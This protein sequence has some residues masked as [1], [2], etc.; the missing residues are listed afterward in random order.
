MVHLVTE[1]TETAKKDLETAVKLLF[2]DAQVTQENSNPTTEEAN[3]DKQEKPIS[4][5]PFALFK[6]YF[7]FYSSTG[8]SFTDLPKNFLVTSDPDLEIHNDNSVQEAKKIFQKVCPGQE[9]FEKIPDPENS[10]WEPAPEE[11][12][13][14]SQEP[15]QQPETTEPSQ[16]QSETQPLS[17]TATTTQEEPTKTQEPQQQESETK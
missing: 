6:A 14:S 7:N 3:E 2:D 1:G 5:K 12:Q 16:P 8:D 11:P 17:T 9:F 15:Q 4:Q 13:P 10:V